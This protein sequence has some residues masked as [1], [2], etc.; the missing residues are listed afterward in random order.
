MFNWKLKMIPSCFCIRP[1]F[2][3]FNKSTIHMAPLP[4]GTPRWCRVG[5]EHD[6]LRPLPLPRWLHEP[7]TFRVV[8]GACHQF[9]EELERKERFAEFSE[10]QLEDSCHRVDV[11]RLHLD[12]DRLL[13]CR[14]KWGQKHF[15]KNIKQRNIVS[16]TIIVNKFNVRHNW[17]VITI[18]MHD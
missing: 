8:L 6:S 4:S 15:K 18:I 10:V 5:C 13:P 11:P 3:V 1:I 12:Q 2:R 9:V 17:L 14:G 16:I 7:F